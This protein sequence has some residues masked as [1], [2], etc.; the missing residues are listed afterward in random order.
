MTAAARVAFV[1]VASCAVAACVTTPTSTRARSGGTETVASPTAV[2]EAGREG[3]CAHDVAASAQAIT[4]F[5]DLILIRHPFSKRGAT[6]AS[7]ILGDTVRGRLR[8][9]CITA[10]LR[11]QWPPSFW[12]VPLYTP[13]RPPRPASSRP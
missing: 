5:L 13:L 11:Q 9:P 7:G 10:H 8:K 1:V 3:T 6:A 12:P 4:N 2:M